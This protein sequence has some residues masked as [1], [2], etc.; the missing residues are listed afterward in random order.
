ML[1]K[2]KKPLN[3]SN[4]VLF[5]NVAVSKLFIFMSHKRACCAMDSYKVLNGF[6]PTRGVWMGFCS[7]TLKARDL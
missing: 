7:F 3:D 5:K 2:Q 6:W 1:L 4:I